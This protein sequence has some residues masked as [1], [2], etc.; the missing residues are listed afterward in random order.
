MK[1]KYIF[2]FLYIAAGL[3]IAAGPMT[4]FHVCIPEDG[5]LMLCNYTARVEFVLG[6][7]ISIA[8]ILTAVQKTDEL[9]EIT[10][11]FAA[12]AAITVMLVA[13]VLVGVCENVHM[14]CHAVARPALNILG[15]SVLIITVIR[16][17]QLRAEGGSEREEQT[18]D[19]IQTFT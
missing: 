6:I 3:L 1:A 13:D 4:I 17:I 2:A 8:G 10:G 14:H 15:A 12:L 19:D 5:R 16:I 11:V 9:Q 7:E 18:P